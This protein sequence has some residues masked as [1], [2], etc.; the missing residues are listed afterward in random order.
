MIQKESFKQFIDLEKMYENKHPYNRI[1]DPSQDNSRRF[2]P[3]RDIESLYTDKNKS[4]NQM[5]VGPPNPK[6]LEAPLIVPKSHDI[7]HWKA[8]NLVVPSFLN[9]NSNYDNYRSGYAIQVQNKQNIPEQYKS[10]TSVD[11]DN[12]YVVNDNNTLKYEQN[13]NSVDKRNYN[14]VS[15]ER[16]NLPECIPK[17][18]MNKIGGRGMTQAEE[19]NIYMQTLQ[20]GIYSTIDTNEPISSNIGISYQ[21]Q[22]KHVL[23]S[24]NGD[25]VTYTESNNFG[26][27]INSDFN[28]ESVIQT[29][30]IY[31]TFDPRFNGYGSDNRSYIDN[32][33]GQQRFFYD[34]INAIKMPNYVSRSNI[35][36]MNAADSYGPIRDGYEHGNPNTKDIREIAELNYLNSTLQFRSDLQE[37]LMR[38]RNSEMHQ[39]RIAPINRN[40]Q[41]SNGGM[42]RF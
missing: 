33:T 40:Q 16:N 28:T 32:T 34:D 12:S 3:T 30:T 24:S 21:P 29:P 4:I 17:Y 23:K 13:I 19:K 14:C 37:S 35:D 20:P 25:K 6:T 42:G 22:F 31:N 18:P 27:L 38:K 39:L 10:S 7:D 2:A 1:I 9:K 41:R 26:E 15:T 5:L 8:N 11:Y 36:F